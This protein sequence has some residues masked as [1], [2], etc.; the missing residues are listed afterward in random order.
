MDLDNFAA[1]YKE[2]LADR[3]IKFMMPIGWGW[4]YPFVKYSS[5]GLIAIKTTL[6]VP[7]LPFFILCGICIR[8][9]FLPMMIRQMVLIHR[10]SKVSPNIRLLASCTAKCNLSIA[11]KVYYFTKSL[12]KYC[13]DVKV[14]PF[15]FAAYNLFQLPVFFLMIMSIRKIAYE[16]DLKD[17]GILWFK[18]LNEPDPYMIL[19][20]ISVCITYYNLGRGINKDNEHW[21]INRWRTLFQILQICYLPF[22]CQWPVVSVFFLIC[23]L[24]IFIG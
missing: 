11:Y 12:F 15:V 20:V 23:R 21:F 14:N 24:L 6:S 5:M 17:C 7:W 4:A 3:K 22:T 8:I 16:Q 13:K 1:K 2:K 19:P 10:M 9:I 18:N